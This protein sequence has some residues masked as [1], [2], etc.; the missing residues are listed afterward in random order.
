MDLLDLWKVCE[1]G[2]LGR[3][4]PFA[5]QCHFSSVQGGLINLMLK[6][7]AKAGELLT[8]GLLML[9]KSLQ[10]TTAAVL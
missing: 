1:R 9:L 5:V 7:A 8:L 10:H 6:P 4:K 3:W 2:D